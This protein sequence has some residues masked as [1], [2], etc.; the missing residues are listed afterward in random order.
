[1]PIF[2]LRITILYR[3]MFGTFWVLPE[4]QVLATGDKISEWKKIGMK[5]EI[6]FLKIVYDTCYSR[7]FWA[8]EF[9]IV[10]LRYL[11]YIH[12]ISDNT[13]I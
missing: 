3:D 12:T 13:R 11:L 2:I 5:S 10:F 4:F 8:T 7:N 1:M 9:S 6:L